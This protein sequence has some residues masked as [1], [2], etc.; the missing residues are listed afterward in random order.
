MRVPVQQAGTTQVDATLDVG[1]SSEE[2]MVEATA[3]VLQTEMASVGQ[4]VIGAAPP[5]TMPPEKQ[6]FTP[7]LRQYFPE[8]LLWLPEVITDKRGHARIS[9]PMADNI[10]AWKMSVI[11]STEGGRSE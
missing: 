6:L 3:P 1:G 8:T 5:D 9:F 11:A 7:R 4:K 2:V 10:T